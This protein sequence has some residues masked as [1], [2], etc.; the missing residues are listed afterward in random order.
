MPSWAIYGNERRGGIHLVPEGVN[1]LTQISAFDHADWTQYGLAGIT[2]NVDGTG[3]FIIEVSGGDFHQISQ[4]V[5]KAA[6][7]IAYSLSVRCKLHPTNTRNRLVI[8]IQ[9]GSGGSG[10]VAIYDIAGGLLEGVAPSAYGSGFSGGTGAFSSA[11]SGW[12]LC[13]LNGVT[14]DTDTAVKAVFGL[15][16]GSGTGATS[17]NYAGNG[18]S[19]LIIDQAIL[20]QD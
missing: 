16:A 4:N 18:T 3:D 5:T 7:S 2:A 19:G 14:T 12:Y 9:N 13:E 8:G 15:D 20:V 17:T 6:S 11:G 10:V 1:L